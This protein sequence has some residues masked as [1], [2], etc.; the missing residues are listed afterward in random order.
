MNATIST[1]SNNANESACK[2]ENE[3]VFSVEDDELDNWFQV[4]IIDNEIVYACNICD[5]GSQLVHIT[6]AR[7]KIL[8]MVTK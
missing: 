7:H 4:E 1:T 6:A 2:E 3:T 8:W 5:E